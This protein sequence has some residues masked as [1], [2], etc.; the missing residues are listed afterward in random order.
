MLKEAEESK[1]K[2]EEEK[3]RQK[4]L[5]QKLQNANRGLNPEQVSL[6]ALAASAEKRSGDFNLKT[7]EKAASDQG[8]KGVCSC[9]LVLL[10]FGD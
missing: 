4:L 10:F 1:K 6:L 5:R 2:A 9:V 8:V 3:A 7:V